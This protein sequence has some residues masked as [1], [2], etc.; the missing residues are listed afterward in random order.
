MMSVAN[1]I[2]REEFE[3]LVFVE[4]EKK[5][6]KTILSKYLEKLKIDF[7]NVE[8]L[9]ADNK[10]SVIDE[11]YGVTDKAL[12][13]LEKYRVKRAVIMAAGFGSRMVPITLN[14]PKPLV[15]VNGKRIIDTI[16]EAVM[17]AEIEEVYLV[18]GYLWEQF[19]AL[20]Y[21]YPNIKFILNDKFNEANNISS[22]L[23]AKE[24]LSNAYVLEADLLIN[25]PKIIRKYEYNTNYTGRY[26]EHTDDW[27][28][29]VEDGIIKEL[30]V[31]G[32]DVYHMYGISYWTE[33]DGK[34]LAECIEKTFNMEDGK[35][36]YWD[37]VSMRVFKDEFEIN[38]RPCFEGDVIE[39]DTFDE[40]TRIDEKYKI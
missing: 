6:E 3:V 8:N 4:R 39:I 24:Y 40:L 30:L 36:K 5:I 10:L 34:K 13:V 16:M 28:F 27:C 25:N 26:C 15:R 11:I 29:K 7:K 32:Y 22:A 31:V 9:V 14:T 18:R 17:E 19:D 2:T 20:L 21:K 33:D 35:Q 12:E 38:V 1:E 23:L 37:E